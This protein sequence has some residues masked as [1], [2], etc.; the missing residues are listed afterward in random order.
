MVNRVQTLRSST[1]LSRPTGRQPGE[2]YV[3]FPDAQLGVVNAASTAQ[4]LIGVRFFSTLTSYAIGDFVIQAGQLYR[5]TQAVA[6]GAFNASQWAQIGGT[7]VVSDALP[8]NPQPGE[9]WFDSVGGQLY[10][11][12]DDGN[13]KQ[14]VVAN[15]I[16][17]GAYLALTGGTMT[18]PLVLA[19]DAAANLNPVTLQQLNAGF[20]PL[21][22]GTLTGT[23]IV[24]PASGDAPLRLNKA[25]S[26][27]SSFIYGQTA[28]VTRW[29]M[30]VGNSG[31][32]SGANV[33]SDF[34]LKR[35]SDAGVSIDTPL[36][37]AR[38]TGNAT[39]SAQVGCNTLNVTS[40]ASIGPDLHCS[41]TI[42]GNVLNST[43]GASIGPDLTCTG[44][45]YK[46][47]GG[48]WGAS[49]DARIK[50]VIGDYELGLEN[51][52]AVQPVRY[53][54]KGNDTPAQDEPSPHAHVAAN[55]TE[56]VGV[57]AQDIESVF[58]DMVSE[59]EGFIDGEPVSDLKSVDA[60]ELIWALVNA[61]KTLAQRVEALE[62]GR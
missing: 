62:A 54:Y 10:C 46:P 20:L 29:Q 41:G 59:S 6:A 61:V 38:S 32:E 13:S 11:Y 33:G 37:I 25:A 57:I 4:D 60:S 19:G 42:Y 43:N 26:G 23:L 17:G 18:G 34:T 3:N 30:V 49:S 45:A 21:G 36:S 53:S 47:G 22:G 7:V 2:L 56:F 12:Y 9:L 55:Q 51:V 48:S 8:A 16:N 28:G 58:P 31:A 40:G 15:T 1:P 52:M 24:A 44:N 27:A 39:F 35:Y 5:A 50:T 14:W